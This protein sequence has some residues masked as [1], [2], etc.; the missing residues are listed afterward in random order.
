MK[1]FLF[2]I[3]ML[4]ST[5]SFAQTVPQ[6]CEGYGQIA[7]VAAEARDQGTTRA[8]FKEALKIA[9]MRKNGDLDGVIARDLEGAVDFA[10]NQIL[11]SPGQVAT[12]YYRE[13]MRTLGN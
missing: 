5:V 12:V 11:L 2:I 13:C 1:T 10:Y 6:R 8:N 4:L 7:G 9:I 3:V